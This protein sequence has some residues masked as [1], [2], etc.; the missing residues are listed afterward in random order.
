MEQVLIKADIAEDILDPIINA[1]NKTNDP[2]WLVEKTISQVKEEE[3]FEIL[4]S[5]KN[6]Y[7]LKRYATFS[8][9]VWVYTI[10]LKNDKIH[11]V[12]IHM[13]KEY[14]PVL[15]VITGELGVILEINNEAIGMILKNI[16][17][18]PNITTLV[19][20]AFDSSLFDEEKS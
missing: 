2:L 9:N 10:F 7:L 11:R 5:E 14:N 19:I 12:E 8:N 18:L 16:P 1:K 15:K 6:I 20:Q 4:E 3:A 13:S 17:E